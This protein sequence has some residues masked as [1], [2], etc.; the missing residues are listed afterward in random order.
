MFIGMKAGVTMGEINAVVL[1]ELNC[2]DLVGIAERHT[3]LEKVGHYWEGPCPFCG[4]KDRYQIKQ[5]PDGEYRWF[6]RGCSD[7]KYLDVISFIERLE[8]VE[9]FEAVTI[10]SNGQIR[11]ATPAE[12][13]ERKRQQAQVEA[14]R[15]AELAR[16]T[17]KYTTSEI[18]QLFVSRMTE[19]NR[20]WW[21]SQGIPD[22]WID[23]WRLGYTPDKTFEYQDKLYHSPAYTIPKF[24]YG[25]KP[26]N[27]D[28]RLTTYPDGAG[29]Y[30]PAAELPPAPFVSRPDM[31]QVTDEVVIVEGSKKAMVCTLYGVHNDNGKI[32]VFGIPSKTSWAGIAAKVNGCGRV[33]IALDPDA[34]DCAYKLAGAIGK[35]ARVME[36][37]FKP[38]DG[39]LFYGLDRKGWRELQK[40]ARIPKEVNTR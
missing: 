3:R 15:L 40:Y 14:E 30:R 12:I 4:G 2:R 18:W 36:M 16:V 1:H 8:H 39:F 23:F 28:Y 29:K 24:D 20:Q 7:G 21:R 38:D 31:E 35:A 34:T 37:P 11:Q 27:I 33:W 6:C 9:F 19:E 5:R 26:T 17:E 10:L 32:H 13:E 25:W 22:I